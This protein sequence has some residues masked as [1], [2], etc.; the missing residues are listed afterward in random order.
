VSSSTW[1]RPE[2]NRISVFQNPAK[3]AE[4]GIENGTH[5]FVFNNNNNRNNTHNSFLGKTK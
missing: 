4:I 1:P 3:G 5:N 2:T